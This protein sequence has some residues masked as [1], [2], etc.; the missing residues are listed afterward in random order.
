MTEAQQLLL[1]IWI[2]EGGWMPAWSRSHLNSALKASSLFCSGV[3]SSRYGFL[4]C[5][6][7]LTLSP[8]TNGLKIRLILPMLHSP[9]GEVESSIPH[10]LSLRVSSM[11][12][13]ERE[14]RFSCF[15]Q[16]GQ[17][18]PGSKGSAKAQKP[19]QLE[20]EHEDFYQV[21]SSLPV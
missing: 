1:V 20:P 12:L 13:G 19:S 2:S 7:R 3:P 18:A 11:P 8:G 5:I 21:T 9:P 14:C 4:L 6:C 15:P 17:G 10:S 16:L